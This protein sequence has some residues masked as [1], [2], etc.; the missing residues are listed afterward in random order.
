MSQF[1]SKAISG[2]K[3]GFDQGLR[4]YFIKVYN[5]MSLALALSAFTAYITFAYQPLTELIFN[6]QGGRLVGYTSLGWIMALAPVG[7]A[8]YFA[9]G[10]ERMSVSTAQTFLWMYAAFTGVSLSVLAFQYTAGSIAKAL[11]I[12]SSTFG[13]ASIYGYST[14]KDLTSMG[15]FLFM[16]IVG[17]LI[18]S[19]VNLYFKSPAIHFITSVI[20]VIVFV[21][22]AAYDT[23]KIKAMYYSAGS[24]ERGQ[25][26]A[27][28][29]AFTLYLD[30][31]NLFVY[32][33]RFVGV[34]K[35]N[36]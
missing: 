5:Y 2:T 34:N 15:S 28:M 30:F 36:D 9:F 18:A 13:A 12:T 17:I 27:I 7:I 33:L 22:L 25:K 35:N 4:S 20:G 8:L 1:H 24:A 29:G 32:L 19:V 3:T 6:I 26:M 14:N 10:M 21:G 31:I 16:G 23:Y 11:L